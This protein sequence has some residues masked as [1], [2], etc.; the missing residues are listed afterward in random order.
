[1]SGLVLADPT[2]ALALA[3]YEVCSST[4]QLVD[5]IYRIYH[6]HGPLPSMC[7]EDHIRCDGAGIRRVDDTSVPPHR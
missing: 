5:F 4:K 1:M 2:Y 3:I 6:G 7:E